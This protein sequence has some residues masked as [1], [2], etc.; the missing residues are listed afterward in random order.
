MK[1][2]QVHHNRWESQ[3]RQAGPMKPASRC[4][5]W[6]DK[7]AKTNFIDAEWVSDLAALIQELQGAS[8]RPD[9]GGNRK[10]VTSLVALYEYR[11]FTSRIKQ[12]SSQC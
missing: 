8:A 5:V 6:A 11:L 4:M 12:T 9:L 1:A 2:R 3:N 7:K 10:A